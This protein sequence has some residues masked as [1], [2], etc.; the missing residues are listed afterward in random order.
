MRKILISLTLVLFLFSCG[1]KEEKIVKPPTTNQEAIDTYQE[2]LESLKSG[3]YF[4]AAKKFSEAEGMLPQIDWAA[5]S[6]LMSSYCYYLINFYD[7]AIENLEKFIKKYPVDK[8][9]PYAHY[10]ITIS[11]YERILDEEK[12]CSAI[13]TR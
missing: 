1:G 4:Y 12:D 7:E 2:G 11:Y 13:N 5:K 10:L 8:N 3:D 9:I 6:A